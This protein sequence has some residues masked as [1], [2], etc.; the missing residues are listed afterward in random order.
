MVQR[1]IERHGGQARAEGAVGQG[2]TFYL[3]LDATDTASCDEPVTGQVR[4]SAASA[5]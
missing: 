4:V 1:I 2:A 3:T 5:G